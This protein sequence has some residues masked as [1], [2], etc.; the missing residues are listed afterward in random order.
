MSPL[1]D[2]A[3]ARSG[4]RD[5]LGRLLDEEIDAHQPAAAATGHTVPPCPSDD[6]GRSGIPPPTGGRV[7]ARPPLPRGGPSVRWRAA[8]Q[9][10]A[11]ASATMRSA[12]A[13]SPATHLREHGESLQD[14]SSGKGQTDG[15]LRWMPK[16]GRPTPDCGPCSQRRVATALRGGGG[17]RQLHLTAVTEESLT[18]GKK[19]EA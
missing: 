9:I 14:S 1:L 4:C 3:A 17:Q 2:S 10:V 18:R 13:N 11:S 5:T 15:A 8:P 6:L 19:R 16:L 12:S 7:A